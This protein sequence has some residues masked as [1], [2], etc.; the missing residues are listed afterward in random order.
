MSIQQI[1]KL[2]VSIRLSSGPLI[3]YCKQVF[4]LS[5]IALTLTL[6]DGPSTEVTFGKHVPIINTCL[7]GSK[8]LIP[9]FQLLQGVGLL[10]VWVR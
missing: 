5:Q 4:L 8:S 7:V 3:P 9:D 6:I 10:V 2:D 1:L